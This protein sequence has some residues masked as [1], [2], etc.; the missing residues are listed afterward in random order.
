MAAARRSIP[1]SKTNRAASAAASSSTGAKEISCAGAAPSQNSK[2]QQ[3]ERSKNTLPPI[4]SEPLA[5]LLPAIANPNFSSNRFFISRANAKKVWCHSPPVMQFMKD[6]GS[7]RIDVNETRRQL[8]DDALGQDMLDLIDLVL[9]ECPAS[10]LLMEN[11]T[12]SEALQ[13]FPSPQRSCEKGKDGKWHDKG[14][15]PYDQRLPRNGNGNRDSRPDHRDANRQTAQRGG[16][17]YDAGNR[18]G[19]KRYDRRNSNERN[20]RPDG[21]YDR[22]NRDGG[23]TGSSNRGGYGRESQSR[24]YDRSE[25]GGYGRR[26]NGERGS[27]SD[28]YRSQPISSSS[29]SYQ[30]TSA[31]GGPR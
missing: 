6:V 9:P 30:G 5:V 25:S 23:G 1:G 4:R 24:G 22:R 20:G 28:K 15:V 16:G 10:G 8:E 14:R 3:I 12:N 26:K 13:G 31:M 19:R 18:D 2:A 7:D 21:K 17:G 27:Y 29:S 11:C